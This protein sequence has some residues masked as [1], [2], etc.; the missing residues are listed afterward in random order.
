MFR[1]QTPKS[2]T[3]FRRHGNGIALAVCATL[4]ALAA[5][6]LFVRAF[7]MAPDV[8]TIHLGSDD[9][10]YRR[11]TNPILGFELKPNYRNDAAD[12]IASYA[13]TNAFG[14]RDKPR[15]IAKR[16]DTERIILLGDSVVEGYGLPEKDTISQQWEN[17]Y[18]NGEKEILNAGVS[19]YCTLAEVELLEKK[20][21]EFAPDVVVLL[22]VENDFDNFNREA[23]PLGGTMDRPV[24]VKH[25]FHASHLF[26]L[27]CVRLNLFHFAAEF[28][29]VA[30]NREAI[31]DNN[32]AVGLQRFKELSDQFGFA[33]LV[34]VWPRFFDDRIEDTP[35]LKDDVLVVES[36]A[37]R[38]GLPT[39]R[40]SS[41]FRQDMAAI[42]EKVNPRL[43]YTL[44]DQL[45][46]STEGCRV[47]A[48][49]LHQ[50]LVEFQSGALAN[51]LGDETAADA[52][53]MA[54]VLG[55]DQ[56]N[57]SRVHNRLGT[58]LLRKG[59][60]DEA[61]E[62]FERALEE[63]PENAGAYNNLGIAYE[64]L[65]RKE[66]QEQFKL[67]IIHQPD[68]AMA[69]F[70]LARLILRNGRNEMAIRGFRQ[71]L[72]IA[73][74]HVEALNLLGRELGK[75]RK[76]SEAEKLLSR[77]IRID[78]RH[79]EVQNNLGV[80]LAAQGKLSAAIDHFR[81]AL[82]ADPK[83]KRA[84]VNLQNTEKLLP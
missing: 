25:L 67:A 15:S 70:N 10:V 63:D 6:E 55:S 46:P 35:I 26:R 54:R 27:T 11:S 40:L 82:E 49:A 23:F 58:S 7:L 33:G 50:I 68:F 17:L 13:R 81:A 18:T 29:P 12:N 31:G 28:D 47:A 76:F 14:F 45:H 52:I 73:P 84:A 19:A 51:H 83:H 36:L 69:H 32:V 74:N 66:A 65:G 20:G 56:P 39:V 8:K 79:A 4:L 43:R 5:V 16:P 3:W 30:W 77:A 22:F 72:K 21:L 62:Q 34:A 9:C 48:N 44:G 37:G 38:N 42:N 61:V 57:Y 60:L 64:Q 24:F 59:K 75:K 1:Y 2:R 53:E 41:F 80:V 78:P 71:V